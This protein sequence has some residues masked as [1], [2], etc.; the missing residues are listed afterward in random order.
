MN[1]EGHFGCRDPSFALP[2]VTPRRGLAARGDLAQDTC[3][4]AKPPTVAATGATLSAV[5]SIPAKS[6]AAH[7]RA[8]SEWS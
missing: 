6:K 8:S 5:S 1:L 3:I 2:L 4:T 7:G